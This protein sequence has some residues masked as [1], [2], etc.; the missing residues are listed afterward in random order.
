M[1]K[2]CGRFEACIILSQ[3]ANFV[4][5]HLSCIL[6]FDFGEHFLGALRIDAATTMGDAFAEFG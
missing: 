1:L 2:K 6:S 4:S 5:F 3:V